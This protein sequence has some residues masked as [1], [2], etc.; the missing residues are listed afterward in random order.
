VELVIGT[1][2]GQAANQEDISKK[3]G[4]QFA[5]KVK[6]VSHIMGLICTIRLSKAAGIVSYFDDFEIEDRAK[7]A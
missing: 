2:A 7:T 4:L 6:M 3:S 1:A 5:I